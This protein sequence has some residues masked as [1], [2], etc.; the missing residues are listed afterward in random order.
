MP[1]KT[2]ISSIQTTL[3]QS[4][5]EENE[6]SVICSTTITTQ[7]G[8]SF[9][10]LGAAKCNGNI[11]ESI[12][13][14]AQKAEVRAREKCIE[15]KDSFSLPQ[16]S[17]GNTLETRGVL[18]PKSQ[19]NG[20]GG[21]PITQGQINLLETLCAGKHNSLVHVC[22]NHYNKIPGQL[23]GFEANELIRKLKE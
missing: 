18:S 2:T 14:A 1:N 8:Q 11:D 10:A 12:Q 19:L 4:P 3:I 9:T 17:I 13:V 22:Q 5:S 7:D 20:G 16:N 21:K 23:T 6:Y 15:Q